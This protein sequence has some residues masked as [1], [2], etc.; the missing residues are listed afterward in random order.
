MNG[1]YIMLDLT[2]YGAITSTPVELIDGDLQKFLD[3]FN[4]KALLL[5]YEVGGY[6]YCGFAT[7]HSDDLSA[8][9]YISIINYDFDTLI[10]Y[11]Y[12]DVEDNTIE[13]IKNE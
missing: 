11:F 1:G 7:I 13:Y 3:A 9:L 4:G 8:N 12:I 5:K 6:L 10:G 2:K